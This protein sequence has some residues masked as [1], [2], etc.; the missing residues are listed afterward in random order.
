MSPPSKRN[1]P[2]YPTNL[3]HKLE[4]NKLIATIFITL[5]NLKKDIPKNMS[6]SL[7]WNFVIIEHHNGESI[8][9]FYR[10][11]P[12][13]LKGNGPVFTSCPPPKKELK[14]RAKKTFFSLAQNFIKE[15]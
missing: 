12:T 13:E 1:R 8:A 9:L 6:F 15:N 14:G 10:N 5:I 7:N 4:I 11:G 3:K 2:T